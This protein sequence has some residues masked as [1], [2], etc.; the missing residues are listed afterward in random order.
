MCERLNGQRYVMSEILSRALFRL[1]FVANIAF[2]KLI[3]FLSRNV[4]RYTCIQLFYYIF[5]LCGA[6][7]ACDI[8]NV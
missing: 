2:N 4:V 8:S 1:G 3:G 7:R 5:T 6:C